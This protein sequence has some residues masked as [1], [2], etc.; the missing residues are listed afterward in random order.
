MAAA[1]ESP[2]GPLPARL[3]QPDDSAEDLAHKQVLHDVVTLSAPPARAAQQL[4]EWVSGDANRKYAA[5]R[6]RGF[7]L[8]AD[9][10]AYLVAPNASRS[11]DM[12]AETVARLC[13]A[14]PP[15]HPAQDALVHLL[16]QLK[17]L[18]RHDVPDLRY[19][20]ANQLQLDQPRQIWLLGTPETRFLAQ[21]FLRAAQDLAYPFSDVEDLGSETQLRWRNLQSFV[22]RITTQDLIDCSDST[23]LLHILPRSHTYPDLEQRKMGGPRRLAADVEAAAQWLLPDPS[24]R[25]VRQQCR[26]GNSSGG[27]W[28]EPNWRRW[29]EQFSLFA[30]DQRL[31]EATRSLAASLRH[32][33]DAEDGA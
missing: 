19:D 18:P 24:R 7:T 12:L 20:D 23:A 21:R 1:Q 10:S 11:M 29:K 5:L 3:F 26:E 28:T 8:A 32:K 9:E 31:P 15:G 27:V 22:A 30:G 13:S 6:D 25:W 16:Q 17:D 14:Y 33:M 2:A 4:D